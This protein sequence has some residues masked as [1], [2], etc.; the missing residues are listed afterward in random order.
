MQSIMMDLVAKAY[1][2]YDASLRNTLQL[3]A[4]LGALRSNAGKLLSPRARRLG[5]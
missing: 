1:Q 3:K 5:G 2:S 4:I